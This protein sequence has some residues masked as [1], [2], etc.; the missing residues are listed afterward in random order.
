M[1]VSRISLLRLSVAERELTA[2]K[3]RQIHTVIATTW[4]LG[5]AMPSGYPH[6][7]AVRRELFDRVCRGVP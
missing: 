7:P 1:T 6:P 4:I 2:E 3:T 5:V